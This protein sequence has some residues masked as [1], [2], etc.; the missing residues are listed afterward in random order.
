MESK[1]VWS[2]DAL[3]PLE[4]VATEGMK[5]LGCLSKMPPDFSRM[6]TEDRDG[7]A[8][9]EV[10]HAV[11]KSFPHC[12]KIHQSFYVLRNF[13]AKFLRSVEKSPDFRRAD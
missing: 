10:F 6:E 12:G 13:R 9:P 1:A 11:E 3:V 4:S 2:R 7:D 8:R 5:M